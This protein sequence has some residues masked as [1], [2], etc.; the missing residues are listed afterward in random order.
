MNRRGFLRLLA[1]ASAVLAAGEFL[2]PQRT[3]FLPPVGGWACGKLTITDITNRALAVLHDNVRFAKQYT[4]LNDSVA[5]FHYE[6]WDRM[7]GGT[8]NIRRAPHYR[9]VA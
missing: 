4:I 8:I 1:N 6:T 9:M 7:G 3:I 2:L 5:D